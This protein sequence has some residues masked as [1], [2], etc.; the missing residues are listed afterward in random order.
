M[1]QIIH[2]MNSFSKGVVSIVLKEQTKTERLSVLEQL[3]P[4]LKMYAIDV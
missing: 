1:K 2:E 4:G 3:S